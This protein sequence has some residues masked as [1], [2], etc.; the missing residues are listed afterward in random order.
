M[1]FISWNVNGIRAAMQKGCM[2]AFKSLDADVIALQETKCSEGQ[3]QPELPGYALY[4]HSAKKKGYSGTAVFTKRAPI[5]VRRSG[6]DFF[7]D[8]EGR[9]LELTFPEFTFVNCYIPNS[10]RDLSRL[11]YRCDWEDAMRG[12]LLELSR[13]GP[14]VYCGDLNVAHREC[15]LKNPAQNR[16]NAGFTDEERMKMTEMLGSGFIDTFR[17]LHPDAVD[18]YTWWSYFAKSRERNIGWRIDYFLVSADLADRVRAAEIY[19]HIH[20]SDHCPIGLE[21]DVDGLPQ[22]G[23]SEGEAALK[24]KG[25]HTS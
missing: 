7:E 17:N 22:R 15:D 11:A 14:V 23:L 25:G 12:Y 20:G 3:C 13:K 10:K 24:E 21:L 8:E 6:I 16:K 9:I 4:W 1:K 5:A 18:R 19:E 2:E